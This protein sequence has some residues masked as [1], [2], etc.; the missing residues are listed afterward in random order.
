MHMFM[1]WWQQANE[2]HN[3]IHTHNYSKSSNHC[4]DTIRH[5]Q[6]NKKLT[7]EY[8]IFDIVVEILV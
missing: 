4:P 5:V 3:I 8:K 2:S 7:D 6:M 1:Y